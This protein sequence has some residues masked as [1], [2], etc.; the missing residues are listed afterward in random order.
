MPNLDFA[1]TEFRSLAREGVA[2]AEFMP[3]V[4]VLLGYPCGDPVSCDASYGAAAPSPA[5][6]RSAP[7]RNVR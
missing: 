2:A 4:Q 6:S 7:A 3:G 1:H 5:A